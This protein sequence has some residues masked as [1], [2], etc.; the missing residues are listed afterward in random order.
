MGPK[1]LAGTR[2][3]GG[4]QGRSSRCRAWG[5]APPPAALPPT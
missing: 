5:P 3:M 2:D 4:G 1:G